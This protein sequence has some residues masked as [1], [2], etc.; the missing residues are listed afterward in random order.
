M[1]AASA[2]AALTHSGWTRQAR[3]NMAATQAVG[4]TNKLA[5]AAS[6]GFSPYISSS[7][8]SQLPPAAA[9]TAAG[10][11]D[12][13]LRL[14]LPLAL[15]S[16]IGGVGFPEWLCKSGLEY[17][18]LSSPLANHHYHHCNSH[19]GITTIPLDTA[20]LSQEMNGNNRTVSSSSTHESSNRNREGAVMSCTLTAA[21]FPPP[22]SGAKEYNFLGL[23]L[24]LGFDKL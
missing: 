20:G 5:T 23:S 12:P 14:P 4:A 8:S 6:S 16:V 17:A 13:P 21:A 24:G 7:S 22:S 1:G 11:G 10:G 19:H 2:K 3:S 18:Q 9:A 15:P